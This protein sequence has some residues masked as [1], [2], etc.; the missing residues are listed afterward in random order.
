[1]RLLKVDEHSDKQLFH[2]TLRSDHC[3][4]EL[5]LPWK[6]YFGRNVRK[7]GHELEIPLAK[8]ERFYAR[9]TA[10]TKMFND[11]KITLS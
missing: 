3:L 2:A 11:N 8:T 6:N 10:T 1:M 4:N 7:N 5:L 9:V